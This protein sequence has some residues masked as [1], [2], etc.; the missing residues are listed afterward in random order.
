LKYTGWLARYG[1]CPPFGIRIIS[2]LT[3]KQYSLFQNYP[4]PFN[5][6]T[7]I[8]FDISKKSSVKIVIYDVTGRLVENL[9]D[10]ELNPGTYEAQW[11]ASDFVSGVYF[12]ELVTDSYTETKKM[13]LLK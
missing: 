2:T 11:D 3:P 13:V 6:N 12:C 4:N 7:L 8:K 1:F 10:K 9:V 5:P